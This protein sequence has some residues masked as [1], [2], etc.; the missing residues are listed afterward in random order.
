MN[1]KTINNNYFLIP[2]LNKNNLTQLF[3]TQTLEERTVF[4]VIESRVINSRG[5]CYKSMFL[6]SES[7]DFESLFT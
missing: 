3:I 7:F 6:D 4:I 1:T 5:N 2:K